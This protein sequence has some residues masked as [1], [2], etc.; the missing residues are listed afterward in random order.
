MKFDRNKLFKLK[1]A[2]LSLSSCTTEEGVV[3]IYDED[4]LEVN[5]EIFVD[6]DEGLIPAPDRD[7]HNEGNVIRVEGGKVT[8]IVSD[9]V[10]QPVEEVVEEVVEEPVVEE[11]P[12]EETPVEEVVEEP[13]V[14]ET[15]VEEPVVEEP[16]VEEPIEETPVEETP[17]EQEVVTPTVEE[18]QVIID[19]QKA[20]IEDLQRQLDEANEKLKE[21]FAVSAEEEFKKVEIKKNEIDFSK[22]V[23][24]RK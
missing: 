10:E 8:A 2:L 6:S 1:K 20:K 9:V 13:V 7:Y 15:P 12:V 19:E 17:V 21:P 4:V 11:T 18:L 5:S 22:Y 16:V 24:I 23:K 3:L 14:E